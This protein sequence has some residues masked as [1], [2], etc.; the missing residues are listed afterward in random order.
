MDIDSRARLRDSG[1]TVRTRL[2]FVLELEGGVIRVPIRELERSFIRRSVEERF[3]LDDPV[4]RVLGFVVKFRRV[5]D[6]R[7]VI[8][9]RF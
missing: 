2:C 3:W 1:R 4:D 7:W 5:E 8:T 6:G 9:I